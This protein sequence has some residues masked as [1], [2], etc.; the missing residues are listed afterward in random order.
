[1]ERQQLGDD[2][3]ESARNPAEVLDSTFTPTERELLADVLRALRGLRYGTV[4][5]TV[6]EGRLVEIQ[7]T[8]RIR[9]GTAQPKT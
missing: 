6:H 7:K 2:R 5:L 3:K 4:T 8:E 1:M 9:R